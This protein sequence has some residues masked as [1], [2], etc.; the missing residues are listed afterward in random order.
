M[1]SGVCVQHCSVTIVGKTDRMAGCDFIALSEFQR[2]ANI[3][4]KHY[5]ISI[6]IQNIS[7]QK[8]YQISHGEM[9]SMKSDF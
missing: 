9:L 7:K 1:A 2:E 6:W 5:D 4:G 8:K 3:L